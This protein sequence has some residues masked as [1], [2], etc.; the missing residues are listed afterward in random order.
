MVMKIAHY[1]D[2]KEKRQSHSCF[3]FNDADKYFNFDLTNIRGYG[4]TQEEAI[5]N[6][7]KEL[8]YYFCELHALEKMLYETN[9]LD[10]DIVEVDCLGRKIERR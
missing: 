6:L 9:V 3:L 5:E 2:G 8:D 10:N 1:N 7:K 4:E